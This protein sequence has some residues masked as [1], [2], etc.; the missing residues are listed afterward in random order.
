MCPQTEII[1][2]PFQKQTIT[3]KTAGKK[4]DGRTRFKE[5]SAFGDLDT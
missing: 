1:N 4:R 3:S 5:T 2:H